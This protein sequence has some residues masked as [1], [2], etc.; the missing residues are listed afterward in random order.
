MLLQLLQLC[1]LL[2]AVLGRRT[3]TIIEDDG[4][5]GILLSRPF[6]FGANGH[7]DFT[8]SSVVVRN[9]T[10]KATKTGLGQLGF[11][12]AQNSGDE[13]AEDPSF[14]SADS[15]RDRCRF[16]RSDY[17][18]KVI[19]FDNTGIAQI[20]NNAGSKKRNRGYKHTV[21]HSG[22][23]NGGVDA[24]FFANCNPGYSVSFD[25]TI[26]MYNIDRWQHKSFLSVGELEMPTMLAVRLRLVHDRAHTQRVLAVCVR[27]APAGCNVL[28]VE[29]SSFWIFGHALKI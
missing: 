28:L 27:T 11:Y 22:L 21:N 13:V 9:D 10:H 6:G 24:L 4:R 25:I 3:R 1:L 8:L 7:L 14:S 15:V 19:G 17:V 5:P 2:P 26:E 12:L 18:E 29:Q 20:V 16:L 23:G